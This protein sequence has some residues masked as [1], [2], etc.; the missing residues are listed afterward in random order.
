[1]VVDDEY[2]V[3]SAVRTILE[4]E[5]YDVQDAADGAEAMAF[6]N[7]GD[8]DI[9]LLDYRLPDTNGVEL[10]KQILKLC[11]DPKPAVFAVTAYSTRERREEC[12]AAGMAAG[13]TFVSLASTW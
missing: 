1:M 10:A 6:V 9:A 3:R 7:A 4:L 11:P 13:V 12:M 8:W 5:G 2:G